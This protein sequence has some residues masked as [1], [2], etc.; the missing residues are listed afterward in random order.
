MSETTKTLVNQITTREEAEKV[1][2]SLLNK[3]SSEQ[4]QNRLREESITAKQTVQEVARRVT[5]NLF[6]SLTV[7]RAY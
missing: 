3:F 1:V 7:Y 5:S 6:R 4:A 2:T